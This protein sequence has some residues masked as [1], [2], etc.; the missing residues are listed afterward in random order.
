[1]LCASLVTTPA[2]AEVSWHVD[3]TA[4]DE[5]NRAA[6]IA[7]AGSRQG[8][9][10]RVFRRPD[11]GVILSLRLRPGFER[12]AGDGC[13]TLTV[14]G[15]EPP[16]AVALGACRL[17]ARGFE[18]TL[19]FIRDSTLASGAVSAL[20]QGESMHLTLRLERVGYRHI[21]MSLRGSRI[22]LRK[23]LG[24]NVQVVR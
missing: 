23:M 13:P 6:V 16:L 20:M 18:A 14:L 7:Q 24:T 3:A 1:M 9:Q 12:L 10:V 22:A 2:L 8:D 5:H 19:G 4:I 21:S 17:D 15:S 11:G